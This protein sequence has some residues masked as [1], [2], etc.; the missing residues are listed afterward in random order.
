MTTYGENPFEPG[1]PE[2]RVWDE[3]TS[4]TA[5]KATGRRIVLTPAS[6]ITPR[7]VKWAWEPEEGGRIPMG[8]FAL[9]AGREGTGK[10]SFALWLAAQITRGTLPGEFYGR[11]RNVVILA[12]EDVWEFTIVPRLIA[13]RADL[14]R[15]Y[16]VDVVSDDDGDVCLSLPLDNLALEDTVKAYEVALIIVDPLISVISDKIDTHREAE[17]RRALDPLAGIAGRTGTIILGIAHFNKSS[18][19]DAAS[20]ITASGAFKNV[21]RSLFGFAV[22]DLT[23][24][25]VMSQVKN[26]LGRANLPSLNYRIAEAVVDTA[27]GP[28]GVGRLEWLGIADRGVD[29]ILGD[30]GGVR[31]VEMKESDR[32]GEWLGK[33]LAEHG[34]QPKT[35]VVSAAEVVAISTRT[36]QRAC[37]SLG[38]GVKNVGYPRR[39]VWHLPSQTVNPDDFKPPVAPKKASGARN[40]DVAQLGIFGATGEGP[41]T[42]SNGQVHKCRSCGFPL[43]VVLIRD[44]IHPDCAAKEEAA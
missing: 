33:Y 5:K 7:R 10:S 6:T 38:I 8:T 18:G 42:E 17:V 30:P 21:P 29:E 35:D 13:A 22:D 16:R 43:D 40:R 26:S 2:W 27:D 39:T 12:V 20:R 34:P 31:G 28:C 9:A 25:S 1:T 19:T 44:G 37:L 15:V 24:E 11:P 36:L 4:P 41:T 23:D 3:R 32:A 14:G